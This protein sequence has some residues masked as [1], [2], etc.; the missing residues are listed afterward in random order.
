MCKISQSIN[1]IAHVKG[2]N[3]RTLHAAHVSGEV[4][5]KDTALGAMIC[6]HDAAALAWP[7]MPRVQRMRCGNGIYRIPYKQTCRKV[8]LTAISGKKK[9]GRGDGAEQAAGSPAR[10]LP[11]DASC[12]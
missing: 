6:L 2:F 4:W 12:A 8:S 11:L 5:L 7:W 1:N 9:T 3:P 10:L